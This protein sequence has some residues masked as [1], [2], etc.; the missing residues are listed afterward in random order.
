MRSFYF[1]FTTITTVG[2]GDKSPRTGF[3]QVLGS[4]TMFMGIFFIAMPLTIVG[5]SFSNSWEKIKSQEEGGE[6]SP[7][8]LEPREKDAGPE[9]GL[10]SDVDAHLS[11]LSELTD[12]CVRQVPR[13][14]EAHGTSLANKIAELRK[15]FD[16]VFGE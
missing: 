10:R 1:I 6:A 11:R 15:H 5:S 12:D 16:E 7:T 2:Y 3:G 13:F 9:V 14:S 8:G 4:L